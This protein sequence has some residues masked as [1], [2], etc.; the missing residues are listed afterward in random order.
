M[1]HS[2]LNHGSQMSIGIKECF[3]LKTNFGECK[4]V[5]K[6]FFGHKIPAVFKLSTELIGGVYWNYQF[7]F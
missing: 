1:T 3:V 6:P 7:Y 4:K 5:F 2:F